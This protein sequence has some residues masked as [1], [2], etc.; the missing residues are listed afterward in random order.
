MKVKMKFDKKAAL[1]FVV[2]YGERAVFACVVLCF[3]FFVYKSFARERYEK[4]PQDLKSAAKNASEAIKR[5]D[6]KP[7]ES[8]KG[9]TPLD[10]I[11]KFSDPNEEYYAVKI[12][13]NSPIFTPRCLRGEPELYMVE[14][15]RGTS[16]VGRFVQSMRGGAGGMG[17]GRMVAGGM[18]GGGNVTP[19]QEM[20]P[21]GSR[22]VMLT[23]LVDLKK[24]TKAFCE[25]YKDVGCKNPQL[26]QAPMYY[27]FWVE[28]AEV[29]D[30]ENAEDLQW[31]QPYKSLRKE[32]N[33]CGVTNSMGGSDG[34]VDP[35]FIQNRIVF[36]LPKRIDQDW[37]E[38]VAR[39]PEIPLL[40]F[41]D[42]GVNG[43]EDVKEDEFEEDP[44][45]PGA[46]FRGRADRGAGM[47]GMGM[48]P[49]TGMRPGMGMAPG[50]EGRFGGTGRLGGF[51]RG[52]DVEE[53]SPYILFRFIDFNVEPG[54]RYKYRVRLGFYNPNYYVEPRFLI[55]ELQQLIADDKKLES[56]KKK[57]KKYIKSPW[58]KPS[59]VVAVP[60]DDQLLLASVTPARKNVDPEAKVMAVHWDMLGGIK[61]SDDF[62]KIRRGRVA[63]FLD[64]E[65]PKPKAGQKIGMGGPGMDMMGP[66][67]GGMMGGLDGPR[68]KK[69]EKKAKARKPKKPRK[70]PAKNGINPGDFGGLRGRQPMGGNIATPPEKVDFKTE[71]LVLDIRGGERLSGKNRDLTKPGEILLL[72][73]D[74]NLVV[75]NDVVDFDQYRK[76]KFPPKQNLRMPRG[77]GGMGGPG[78]GMPPG[79]GG[80]GM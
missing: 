16:G 24:Q 67:F 69:D 68:G 46:A 22:W 13:F 11:E 30:S 74:G 55:P 20:E 58:S 14:A 76:H 29:R 52:E 31:E 2:Q 62:E 65:M 51:V 41:D 79:M 47:G 38:S 77:R 12:P 19:G 3:L 70:K 6:P 28:R 40:G 37:D 57:W 7:P 63:N 26:D 21:L 25:C 33:K 45:D 56:A 72:D 32:I 5:N 73:P 50:M 48:G 18:R 35:Y 80:P 8:N 9:E 42:K 34:F 64:H 66:G 61:V 75:R 4:T 15:L 10:V 71:C 49:G 43:K 53:L 78:M 1:G 39:P 17:M 23:G 60:R 54:K 36:P 44:D 59:D 27:A